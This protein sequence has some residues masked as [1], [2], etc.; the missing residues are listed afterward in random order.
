MED[1]ELRTQ[2]EE[3]RLMNQE[4]AGD[5]DQSDDDGLENADDMGPGPGGE[6]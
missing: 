3:L 6:D 4:V 5:D 2:M 1:E